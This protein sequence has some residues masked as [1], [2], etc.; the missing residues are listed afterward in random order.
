[1]RDLWWL[2]GGW[3]RLRLTSADCIARLEELSRTLRLL[4]VDWKNEIT[5]EFSLGERDAGTL[6]VRDG[7][8]IEILGR[9][10]LPNLI[11]QGMRWKTLGVVLLTLGMLTAWIPTRVLFFTVEGNGDVPADRILEA[12]EGAGLYFGAPRREIRSEAVK[13]HL[14]YALPEL[15]WAGVNTTGCVAAITVRPRSSED[16][17]EEEAFG[18]IVAV[19][20]ALVTEIYPEAGTALVRRGQAV[21]EG[22]VLLCGTTDLG[23]TVRQDRAAGEVYGL[24]RHEITARLP[25]SMRTRT[26]TGTD[27]KKYSLRIGKKS[28]K[29]TNHS[30]ILDTTCVKMVTVNYLT[31]P[32][33]FRLPV[34]LVTE[35]EYPCETAV[36]GRAGEAQ[37]LEGTRDYLLGTMT[38][39]K[40]LGEDIRTRENS[41]EAVFQCRELIGAFRPGTQLEGETNDDR[42]IGERGAG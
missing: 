8:T 30:G 40:I 18:D 9:H 4:D 1:M 6:I 16:A 22:D 23:I 13:N 27:R 3:R 32:G 2:L 25:R 38:A 28:I 35:T 15:R 26:Q 39:G 24:T 21:H 33:G 11:R 14:L 10:G 5:V 12:A 19:R 37:L 34:A 29:F 31:L 20:D 41:L 7:E 42:E 36:T 17:V